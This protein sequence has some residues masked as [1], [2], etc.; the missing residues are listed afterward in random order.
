MT[1]LGIFACIAS[2][3]QT[4]TT[5]NFGQNGVIKIPSS[6]KNAELVPGSN[7]IAVLKANDNIDGHNFYVKFSYEQL[8]NNYSQTELQNS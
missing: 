3:S 2:Y 4:F 7:K 8:E 5:Y 1:L 6:F